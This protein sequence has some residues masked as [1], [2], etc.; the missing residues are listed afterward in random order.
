MKLVGFVDNYVDYVNTEIFFVGKVVDFV[1]K[2]R[3]SATKAEEMIFQNK[4]LLYSL[5]IKR[6]VLPSNTFRSLVNHQTTPLL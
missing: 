2:T 6:I 1:G 4:L 5:Y 3:P